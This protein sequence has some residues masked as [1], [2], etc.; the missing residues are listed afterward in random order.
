LYLVYS[1]I[2]GI[3]V[4][5][6]V[7]RVEHCPTGVPYCWPNI[8]KSRNI[9]DNKTVGKIRQNVNIGSCETASILVY[10]DTILVYKAKGSPLY[11]SD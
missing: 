8:T 3:F 2:F 4:L 7:R 6:W 9:T 11:M 10:K 5:L 1:Q